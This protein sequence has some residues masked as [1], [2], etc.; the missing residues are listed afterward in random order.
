[1]YDTQR[2][3]AY[4]ITYRGECWAMRIDPQS[5]TLLDKAP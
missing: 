2:R 4:V 1:M 3:C 5:L